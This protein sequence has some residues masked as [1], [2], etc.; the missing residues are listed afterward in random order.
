MS[1][2]SPQQVREAAPESAFGDAR[3]RLRRRLETDTTH[4]H[5]SDVKK[6]TRLVMLS[7]LTAFITINAGICAAIF[8]S[9][10]HEATAWPDES[11]VFWPE[12]SWR[13]M[14]QRIESLRLPARM[15][16]I[17]LGTV[18]YNQGD[19]P[20]YLFRVSPMRNDARPLKVLL[21]SGTH[22]T[23]TAGVE[24]LLQLLE[25]LARAPSRYPGVSFDIV[26]LI[27]PWGWVYGYRYNGIG[28]DVNRDY[29]SR[30]TEEARLMRGLIRRD[31]PFDLVMDL[32]ESK[33]NGYFIYQYL[34]PDEGLGE[35][36]VRLVRSLGK[37]REDNYSEWIFPARDGILETPPLVLPWIALGQSLSLEQY[38]RMHG[39]RHAYTM[40]SPVTDPLADRVAVHQR[41]ARL[42]IDALTEAQTGK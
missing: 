36:Y 1:A 8:I 33:K 6:R 4:A 34:P 20:V 18:S 39:T 21:V 32:H 37:P 28:E 42:F 13:P 40:E 22:G 3:I 14:K 2:H 30:R 7:I 5:I 41:A 16:R 26:P 19:F 9:A 10:H 11:F 17:V 29:A 15:Q 38:A 25:D 31:G 23:E 27:N 24:A 12:R 35:D